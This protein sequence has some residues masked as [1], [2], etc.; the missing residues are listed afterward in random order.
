VNGFPL[1]LE[2]RI[3]LASEKLQY[4]K[5]I[6]KFLGTVPEMRYCEIN[7]EKSSL[8]FGLAIF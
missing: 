3:V 1:E 5:L 6:Y 4:R 2:G 8:Y 7:K